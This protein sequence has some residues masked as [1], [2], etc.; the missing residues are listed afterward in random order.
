VEI[1]FP[2]LVAALL[3]NAS[4][5]VPVAQDLLLAMA[6]TALSL[7]RPSRKHVMVLCAGVALA[8]AF[9]VAIGASGGSPKAGLDTGLR[10][11]TGLAW[12]VWFSVVTSWRELHAMGRKWS[13][14]RGLADAADFGVAHGFLFL[15]ELER[16]R[17]AAA[18]RQGFSRWA[19][20][21]PS[22][23]KVLAGTVDAAITRGVAIEE[24]RELRS[25]D[26]I[27]SV[28]WPAVSL[29]GVTLPG[30]EGTLRVRDVSL[31]LDH[32]EHCALMGPSGSGKSTLL[33]IIAGLEHPPAGALARFGVLVSAQ[34]RHERVDRR[35]ALVFQNPDD[36]F[37]GATPLDDI[38]W[39]LEQIGHGL[40]AART[41][42]RHT[43]QELGIAP[44]A[45]RPVHEL[46][47][48]EK[49]RVAFAGAL[50]TSPDVLLC[51]EPTSGL[52]PVAARSLARALETETARRGMAVIW[53]THDPGVLPESMNRVILIRQGAI[54]FDGDRATG[55]SRSLLERAGLAEPEGPGGEEEAR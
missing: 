35:V 14:S 17:D 38:A 30:A 9:A 51:D 47:F 21:A 29:R 25:S 43:L 5:L 32:G 34:G 22:Y 3:V 10:M 37:L 12:C 53:V 19:S 8:G 16:R 54:V 24:A 1:S 26:R 52:D 45:D 20:I 23:G 50:A 28:G 55:L 42:A 4:G 36:Q 6:L 39:G 46:S 48:G 44:L 11:A 18:V 2:L 41:L 13:W 7:G 49:K 40:E 31:A 15:R 33:R 27:T